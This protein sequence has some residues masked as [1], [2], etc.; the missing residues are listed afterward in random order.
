MYA[1]SQLS[2]GLAFGGSGWDC[3]YAVQPFVGVPLIRSAVLSNMLQMWM[4]S[5]VRF[6][7]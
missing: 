5:V 6:L 7:Q 2:V 4:V 3:L 1:V